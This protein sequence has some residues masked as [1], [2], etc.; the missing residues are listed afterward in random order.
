MTENISETENVSKKIIE[1][2]IIQ[3]NNI[4]AEA[5]KK[6]DSILNE[7]NDRKE[8]IIAEGKSFAKD[9]YKHEYE[10][11][12]SQIYSQLN[13]ELL[14]EKIKIV[15][16]VIN[17]IIKK[18][19]NLSLAD[20]KKLLIKFAQEIN[21]KDGVYQIG[22]NEKRIT[23]E[24]VK[25]V[26]KNKPLKKSENKPNFEKGLKI[27]DARKE[28]YFSENNLIDTQSEDIKMEISKL[29]FD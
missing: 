12:I 1:D 27:I 29:I 8:T 3:K 11:L 14:K 5:N 21:I 25:E 24:M 15:E 2:A 16:E 18:L 17:E 26:F 6:A 28:Y 13:Q 4:I 20:F 9:S 22:I 19:E 23:D 7:A 10:F